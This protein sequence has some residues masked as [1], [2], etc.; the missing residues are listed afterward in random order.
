MPTPEQAQAPV[1][2]VPNNVDPQVQDP[3]ASAE[4]AANAAQEMSALQARRE[5]LRMFGGIDVTDVTVCVGYK[6]AAGVR[7]EIIRQVQD[8][9]DFRIIKCTHDIEEQMAVKKEGGEII[10]FEPTGRY[11]L[12]V[13]VGFVRN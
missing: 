13:E 2:L 10:G 8:A 5:Q 4:A 11:K 9:A 6:D 7:H 12:K 3:A 1:T